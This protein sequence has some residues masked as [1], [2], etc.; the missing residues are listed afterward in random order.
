[1]ARN[2]VRLRNVEQQLQQL[3]IELADTKREVAT[4][5]LD[6]ER[7]KQEL[8][9]A[10]PACATTPRAQQPHDKMSAMI[11]WIY[12]RLVSGRVIEDWPRFLAAKAAA[13]T[14]GNQTIPVIVKVAHVTRKITNRETW[15]SA[16]FT[17]RY[18]NRLRNMCLRFDAS[19][20][21]TALLHLYVIRDRHDPHLY[22][23]NQFS[24]GLKVQVL[25]QLTY[26]DHK[27]L[28]VV[29]SHNL[30]DDNLATGKVM[31]YSFA[32]DTTMDDQ[33]YKN[34]CM[35]FEVLRDEPSPL[36]VLLISVV[37]LAVML[38]ILLGQFVHYIIWGR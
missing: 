33:W 32:V 3:L 12:N 31:I 14:S 6:L 15:E 36:W 17:A 4:T 9:V 7:I 10:T 22:Q 34:D 2:E 1:M 8:T 29:A 26:K 23:E 35:F 18:N 19:G 21:N 28:P 5:K 25:N 11:H 27:R 13:S 16:H 20:G 37:I 30:Y 38:L 24:I